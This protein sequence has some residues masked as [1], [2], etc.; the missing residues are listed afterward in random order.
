MSVATGTG[1]ADEMPLA[2]NPTPRQTSAGTTM[3]ATAA[4]AGSAARR[5]DDSSPTTSSRFSSHPATKKKTASSPSFAQVRQAQPQMQT[6]DVQADRK[7]LGRFVCTS[8]R[9]VGDHESQSGS[10]QQQGSADGLGPQQPSQLGGASA[11]LLLFRW[12][13]I[14]GGSRRWAVDQPQIQ[15]IFARPAL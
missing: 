3:P 11:A 1:Q 4:I 10:D 6:Q 9:S 8:Q 2:P 7:C 13:A 14:N 5:T 15:H 12:V